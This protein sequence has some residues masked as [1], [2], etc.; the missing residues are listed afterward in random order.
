[1]ST[2]GVIVI[3]SKARDLGFCRPLFSTLALLALRS[4]E[5]TPAH[6]PE[7]DES[8]KPDPG[9]SGPVKSAPA[10]SALHTSNSR[11]ALATSSAKK[12]ALP[13]LRCQ[14]NSRR[15]NRERPCCCFAQHRR[16][17][18]TAL[19]PHLGTRCG[20]GNRRS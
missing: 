7:K 2:I 19:R 15:P 18:A 14:S 1:M 12:P 20:L 17:R 10:D 11:C 6:P 4:R 13:F 16:P 3:P 8:P 9:S 5:R